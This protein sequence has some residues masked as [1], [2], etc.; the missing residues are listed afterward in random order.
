MTWRHSRSLLHYS[1]NPIGCKRITELECQNKNGSNHLPIVLWNYTTPDLWHFT[2]WHNDL[3]HQ[4]GC[5]S[6]I[7][8]LG[9]F[10]TFQTYRQQ[11]YIILKIAVSLWKRFSTDL[12]CKQNYGNTYFS[13]IHIF[14]TICLGDQFFQRKLR[15]YSKIKQ[16]LSEG[17]G[18]RALIFS[19]ILK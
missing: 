3:C 16:K 12:C 9:T 1:M 18:S 14:L 15:G 5:T 4:Y 11:K 10:C 7:L 2:E 13:V 17:D 6:P 8:L 19:K